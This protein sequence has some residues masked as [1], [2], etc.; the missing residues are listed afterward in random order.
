MRRRALGLLAVAIGLTGCTSGDAP[1]SSP[2]AS[3]QEPASSG[4]PAPDDASPDA[5]HYTNGRF[6]YAV[7]VPPDL[8]AEPPPQNDDG[9]TFAS[10]DGS[11]SLTVFGTNDVL[12]EGLDGL[13]EQARDGIETVTYEATPAGG[14]VVSGTS[15]AEVIYTRGLYRDGVGV[16]AQLRYPETEAATYD[17]WAERVGASLRW[18][19]TP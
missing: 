13:A 9:R 8:D 7:L 3:V 5:E 16:L 17:R 19:E 11:V 10:P 4:P 12:G 2:S 14:I 18:T 6:G 1:D 15:D